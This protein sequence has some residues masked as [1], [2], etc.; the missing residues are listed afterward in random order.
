[1]RLSDDRVALGRLGEGIAASFLE[2][3]GHA[4]LGRRLRVRHGVVD[5]VTQSGDH[6]YFVEVKTRR[7]REED[8]RFG[9]G[10]GALTPRKMRRME[11]TAQVLIGRRNWHHLHPH[12]AVL[13]VEEL[14]DRR[15]IRF[16]PD[17]FDASR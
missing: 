2:E 10:L 16:L 17:A 8:D 5:L 15:R 13:T 4:V 12:F 1:M 9:G 3:R 14:P 6:L 11:R 7:A